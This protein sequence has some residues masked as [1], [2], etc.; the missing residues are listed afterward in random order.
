MGES[1]DLSHLRVFGS[2]WYVIL[3]SKVK[4]LDARSKAGLIMGYS[5]QSKG[6]KVWDVE[7]SKS[8]ASRDITFTESSVTC[9]TAEIPNGNDMPSTIAV[10]GGELNFEVANNIDLS[11]ED[12]VTRIPDN[13]SIDVSND[14]SNIE[15]DFE[16]AQQGP[17]PP[18][19]RSTRN[20][21][22]PGQLYIGDNALNKALLA[23]EVVTSYKTATTP[24]NI[25]FWLLGIDMEH[26]CLKHK[27]TW[28]LKD[29]A[30]GMKV[31]PCKYVFKVKENKPKVRLV[32]L[33][34]QQM[35]GVDYNEMFAP[36]VTMNTIRTVLAVTAHQDLE[37]QQMDVFTAFLNGDL[38]E[39]MYMAV[40]EGLK[41][42]AASNKVCKLLNR[43]MV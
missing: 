4:K 1:P 42:N 3:K 14:E 20:R 35:H 12:R 23:Q 13:Q 10:P 28:E 30:H 18:L 41:T 7:S 25:P 43:Y 33:G 11:P 9:Q 31:S 39:D 32:A 27:K 24:E 5:S 37:L 26:D 19:R 17:D 6:Y 36:V 34:C 16:A 40:P 2:N 22:P 21:R 38:D 29:Y 15:N 8:I